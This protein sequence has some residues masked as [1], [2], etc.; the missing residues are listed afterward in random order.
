VAAHH[1][2][3]GSAIEDSAIEVD[4][5][6][7]RSYVLREPKAETRGSGRGVLLTRRFGVRATAMPGGLAIRLEC[8]RGAH[9]TTYCWVG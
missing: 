3:A 6:R 9:Q 2:T 7:S 4:S 1:A 5:T 8:G